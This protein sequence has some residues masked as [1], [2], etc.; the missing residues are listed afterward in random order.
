M[1]VAV[2]NSSYHSY[3]L[4]T[5]IMSSDEELEAY[6]SQSEADREENPAN[7]DTEAESTVSA[8]T[9]SKVLGNFLWLC[10]F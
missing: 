1:F 6:G 7:D 3:M 9:T 2:Q 4:D 5:L 10:F 8:S